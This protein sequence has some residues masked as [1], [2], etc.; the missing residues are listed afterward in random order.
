MNMT[1][2]WQAVC[3]ILAPFGIVLVG[4]FLIDFAQYL[5]INGKSWIYEHSQKRY[6][7]ARNKVA[8]FGFDWGWRKCCEVNEINDDDVERI[9]KNH[10]LTKEEK[11]KRVKV[12]RPSIAEEQNNDD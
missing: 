11:Q 4:I 10:F 6:G 9:L 12:M 7:A 5:Y 2:F 8:S 1:P 3:L